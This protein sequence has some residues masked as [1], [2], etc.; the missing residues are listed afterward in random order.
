MLKITIRLIVIFLI[1]GTQPSCVTFAP[2]SPFMTYGGPKTTPKGKSEAAIALGTSVALFDGAHSGGE[3]WFTRYKYG[4]TEKTDFG[5]DF[6]GASRNDGGYFAGKV[7]TRHQLGGASRLE[8]GIGAADDSSGKSL[9]TDLAV[10][11]GTTKDKTWNYYTS[12]RFAYAKGFAPNSI[13]LPGQTKG[14]DSIPPP[15]TSFIMLN[16]G[17]QGEISDKQ[18]FIFEGGYGYILPKDEKNGPAFYI[19]AGL[20][21]TFG[22]KNE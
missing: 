12:L 9:N 19:S 21:F 4:I 10:T 22:R 1:I 15:N 11:I 7:A 3:G 2:P 17:A 18:K 5:I 6:S 13:T 14:N 8:L 20:L 16:L